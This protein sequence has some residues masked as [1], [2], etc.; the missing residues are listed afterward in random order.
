MTR[1][2]TGHARSRI[3]RLALVAV[4]VLGVA[5][6]AGC[7]VGSITPSGSL[8]TETRDVTG[9]E[10][11]ALRGPGT[12][13]IVPAKTSGLKVTADKNV[14]PY[15][16]TS[17]E[18]NLLV[19]EIKRGGRPVVIEPGVKIDIE[20]QATMITAIENSGSGK[21]TGGPFSGVQLEITNSG[22]GEIGIGGVNLVS[23]TTRVSGSGDVTVEGGV[24][25]AQE[26]D[27][28]GAGAFSAPGL[29]SRVANVRVSGSGDVELWATEGLDASITG[30]GSVGYWG[31]P[32][33][34]EEASGSGKIRHLGRKASTGGS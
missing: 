27:I 15:I 19:I 33:L 4:A 6:L 31:S 32:R 18:G 17:V 13:K 21:I 1:R 23:L 26:V 7:S 2:R 28:S 29:E 25:G 11:V 34:L 8:E 5:V 30:A 12:V 16:A 22:S 9:F 24:V 3:A 10:R 14:M 20:L